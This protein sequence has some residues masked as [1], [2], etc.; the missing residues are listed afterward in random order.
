MI[1]GF[2]LS[3]YDGLEDVK[4]SF[5]ILNVED[6]GFGD[7][8]GRAVA[9]GVPWGVY[10]WIYPGVRPAVSWMHDRT[11]SLGH[12]EPPV[13]YWADYEEGGV[14]ADQLVDWFAQC[15]ALPIKAGYYSGPS[16]VDH[17]PFLTRAWWCAAYPWGDDRY[18]GVDALWASSRP[19]PMQLWQFTSTNGTLDQDSVEDEAWWAG[20]VGVAPSAPA[21]AEVPAPIYQEN[22]MNYVI[23]SGASKRLNPR[24]L[25][26]TDG[27]SVQ[28]FAAG[29]WTLDDIAHTAYMF[30]DAGKAEE[31]WFDKDR[32]R[33]LA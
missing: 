30:V 3:R 2:D 19:R 29:E 8:A 24:D 17:G 11:L 15:D 31:I 23:K 21:A 26:V 1:F 13:G 32:T 5:V 27:D 4:P 28:H 25:M 12:G 14:S 33:G 7:K 10:L 6:P 22:A 18:P 20:W 16:I 9:L